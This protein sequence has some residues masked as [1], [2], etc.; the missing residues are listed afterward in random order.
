MGRLQVAHPAGNQRGEGTLKFLAQ[1]LREME[2]HTQLEMFYRL[3]VDEA[4]ERLGFLL[5]PP[6]DLPKRDGYEKEECH[7]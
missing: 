1:E 6:G 2:V 3:T 4:V 5:L 7:G